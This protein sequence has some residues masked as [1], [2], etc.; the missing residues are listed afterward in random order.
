MASLGNGFGKPSE[1]DVIVI[2]WAKRTRRTS[3]EIG[4]D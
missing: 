1:L 4:R 3:N 2:P